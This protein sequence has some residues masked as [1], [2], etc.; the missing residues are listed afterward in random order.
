M[1]CTPQTCFLSDQ[2]RHCRSELA[3]KT[4]LIGTES[5]KRTPQMMFSGVSA[6]D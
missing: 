6:A 4:G 3:V 5:T 2:A 1:M